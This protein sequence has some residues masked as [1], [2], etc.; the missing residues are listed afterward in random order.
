MYKINKQVYEILEE[1]S[2]CTRKSERL[3]VLEKYS[4]VPAFKDILRG[5]FDDT[6][7]FILPEGRPPFTLNKPESVP[8]TLLKDHVKFGYFVKG[9]AGKDMAQYRVENLFIKLLESIHPEDAEIVLKMVAKQPPVKY[10]TK[11]LVKEAF[12]NLIKK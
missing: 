12:P 11:N 5:T 8:R 9:G 3:A 6:L 4:N 10:L 7:E 1:F 2:K